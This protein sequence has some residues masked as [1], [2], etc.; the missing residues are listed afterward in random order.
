MNANEV[1]INAKQ[2]RQWVKRSYFSHANYPQ[3][4]K[5]FI[6]ETALPEASHWY[7][8]Q[9]NRLS[10]WKVITKTCIPTRYAST[11]HIFVSEERPFDTPSCPHANR[12]NLGN[13]GDC[14]VGLSLYK[15]Y[16]YW[17]FRQTQ[18]FAKKHLQTLPKSG[19]KI[20]QSVLKEF[21]CVEMKSPTLL[22]VLGWVF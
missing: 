22:I 10:G 14:S 7:L 4:V 3:K 17:S 12:L 13:W 18:Q 2:S 21:S 15:P 16:M 20:T 8:V 5:Q 1:V 11:G 19:P 6:G 9:G